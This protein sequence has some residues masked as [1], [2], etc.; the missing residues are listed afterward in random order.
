MVP[1][2]FFQK[3]YSVVKWI[4]KKVA[5]LQKDAG[6]VFWILLLPLR[7]PVWIVRPVM[8]LLSTFLD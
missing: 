3:V 6:P 4:E 7:V 1:I 8:I 2:H 5:K